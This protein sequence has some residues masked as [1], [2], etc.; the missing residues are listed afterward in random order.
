MLNSHYSLDQK[1]KVIQKEIRKLAVPPEATPTPA[2]EPP[3]PPIREVNA[4]PSPPAPKSGSKVKRLQAPRAFATV[5]E[6]EQF[7]DRL[8]ESMAHLKAGGILHIDW[9]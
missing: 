4:P 2:P 3:P 1:I 8:N 5:A 7:I 9:N 6:L